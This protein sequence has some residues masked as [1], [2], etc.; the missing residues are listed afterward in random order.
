MFVCDYSPLHLVMQNCYRYAC[1][2]PGQSIITAVDKKNKV[3]KKVNSFVSTCKND[4]TWDMIPQA[5]IGG[6]IC[7]YLK[8]TLSQS[9]LKLNHDFIF[10]SS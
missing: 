10:Q 3:M 6:C 5:Q 9:G 8:F 2:Q 4:G 1:M 7:K